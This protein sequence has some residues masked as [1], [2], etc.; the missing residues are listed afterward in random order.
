MIFKSKFIQDFL[1]VGISNIL[2]IAFNLGASIIVAR[3]LGPDKNGIIAALLVYPSLFMS[4]GSLGIRQSTAY[5]LGKGVFQEEEIKQAI[6]QIWLFTSILSIVSSFLLIYYL[7]NSSTDNLLILIAILPIPF[8]LF[9]TYNSGIFLG[10]NDLK[11]FN[12]I[13]WLPAAFTFLLTIIFVVILSWDIAGAMLGLLGGPFVMFFILLGKNKFFKSFTFTFNFNVI[14]KLLSLGSVYALTL[15]VINLNYK[16][17]IILLDRL[18]SPYEL[19]IYSKGAN[20]IQ[21]LWQIPMVLSTI[22]FARSAIAKDGNI[23]SLK[24]AQLLRVSLLVVTSISIFLFLLAYYVITIVY[25][26]S[27]YDSIMVLR[28]LMPGVVLMT[29]FKVMNMDLAGKG[30]PWVSMKAMGPALILNLILNVLFIPNNGA[31]G[32]ALASTVS[33]SLAGLLFL[34]F[35]SK[36]TQLSI[37]EILRFRKND[38]TKFKSM[39]TLKKNTDEKL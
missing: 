7:G 38:F 20:L 15:L 12:K 25:G 11:T 1:G 33:Y 28:I 37:V 23:F 10:K 14:F 8:N 3:S 4:I 17:D 19:G 32:A 2:I 29:I 31:N 30:K 6:T 16:L 5:F 34:F 27:F 35:Y 13:N 22:V 26:I 36:E 9:N 24:V 39:L 18:S 21:Y